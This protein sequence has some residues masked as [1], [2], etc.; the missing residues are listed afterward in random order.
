MIL[1]TIKYNEVMLEMLNDHTTYKLLPSDPTNQYKNELIELL[2]AA[3]GKGIITDTEYNFLNVN[4]PRI[5][6]I[7]YRKFIKIWKIHHH[8]Q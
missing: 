8:D 3:K 2:S 4:H 5:P 7:I 6:V 1:E